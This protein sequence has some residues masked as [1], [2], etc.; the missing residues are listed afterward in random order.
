MVVEWWAREAIYVLYDTL[1]EMPA[2][3]QRYLS[4][5]RHERGAGRHCQQLVASCG[6]AHD[7]DDDARV[8]LPF[9]VLSARAVSER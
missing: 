4:I 6:H 2:R 3:I 9:C 7:G 5:H 1:R 8:L